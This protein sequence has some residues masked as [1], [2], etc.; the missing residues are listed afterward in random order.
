VRRPSVAAL[1]ALGFTPEQALTWR[2]WVAN[3]PACPKTALALAA[4]VLPKANAVSLLRVCG[5]VYFVDMGDPYEGTLLHTAGTDSIR[6]GCW[7]DL[8]EKYPHATLEYDVGPKAPKVPGLT[9]PKM[10]T[11]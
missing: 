4:E 2:A 3:H 6:I 11:P 9:A 7:G 10:E 5:G 1:V 8:A